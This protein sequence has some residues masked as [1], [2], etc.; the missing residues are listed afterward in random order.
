M[1]PPTRYHRPLASRP[2]SLAELPQWL[3]Y[4]SDSTRPV[5][6]WSRSPYSIEVRMHPGEYRVLGPIFMRELVTV[7][8]RAGHYSG[9]AA[10]IGLLA[11]LGITTWQATVGFARRH[12]R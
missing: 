9:R 3:S 10:L 1:S 12:T 2:D 7:P 5:E 4:E 8:R 6:F 11:I